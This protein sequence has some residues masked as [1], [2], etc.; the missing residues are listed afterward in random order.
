M[1][2][3]D[4]SSDVCSSDLPTAQAKRRK[5]L[6][7][8]LW[9]GKPESYLQAAEM[10]MAGDPNAMALLA[11]VEGIKQQHRMLDRIGETLVILFDY[12]TSE[13]DPNFKLQMKAA[14]RRAKVCGVAFITL[15]FQRLM[16]IGRA[17]CRGRV[18]QY[19]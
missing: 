10:A 19:V 1:R 5:R 11:E 12:F 14:V 6:D 3:S 4:W 8:T 18:C 17:S 15:D 13:P 7:A 2:I 9:D 16:A